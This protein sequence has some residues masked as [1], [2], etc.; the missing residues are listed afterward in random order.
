MIKQIDHKYCIDIAEI[1]ILKILIIKQI[2]WVSPE[3]LSEKEIVTL[4]GRAEKKQKA[5]LFIPRSVS[6]LLQLTYFSL[7]WKNSKLQRFSDP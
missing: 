2:I 4:Q 7:V 6:H 5:N 1:K 3:K